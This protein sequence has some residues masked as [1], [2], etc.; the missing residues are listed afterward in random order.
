MTAPNGQ[1]EGRERPGLIDDGCIVARILAGDRTAF[2]LL[3]RRHNEQLY[4]V[5]RAVLRNDADAQDALQEAYLRAY[6]GLGAFE[7]RARLA[8]WLTR[9]VFRE[10]IRLRSARLRRPAALVDPFGEGVQDSEA[11]ME[12]ISRHSLTLERFDTAMA[13][14]SDH[15]RAVVMLRWVQGLSTRETALGLGSTESSVKVAL[16]RARPKL[17]H[18]LGDGR[19]DAV[20]RELAFDGRRCDRLVARVLA[21]LDGAQGGPG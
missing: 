7:G 4:R 16:H 10:A 9:I 5:A 8:T 14:L 19:V 11:P 17:A 15:E 18:A 20:R 1:D 12:P 6:R 13:A 2:E 21:A 3:M